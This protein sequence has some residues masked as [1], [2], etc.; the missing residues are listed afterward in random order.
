MK[1]GEAMYK[2]QSE[3]GSAGADTGAEGA[4]DDVIDA[5]FK[6]VGDDDK[7]KSA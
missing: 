2:A 6:E 1:L 4:K 5:D 7:K 3:Q